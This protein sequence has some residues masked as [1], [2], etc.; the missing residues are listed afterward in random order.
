METLH[1]S[2]SV[3]DIGSLTCLL[4]QP[5]YILKAHKDELSD[6]YVLQMGCFREKSCEVVFY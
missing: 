5:N 3:S 6:L 2:S 1:T 4:G